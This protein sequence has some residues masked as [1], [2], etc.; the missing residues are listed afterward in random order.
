SCDPVTEE[1]SSEPNDIPSQA[2]ALEEG[3]YIGGVC[4]GSPDF[5]SITP[6]RPDGR[7]IF[8]IEF[9][10]KDGDL[11]FYLWDPETDRAV[12]DGQ[13]N[14]VGSDSSDDDEVF[15]GQGT[16]TIKIF[17]YNGSTAVYNIYLRY[18]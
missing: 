10:Q 15:Q 6:L 9:S 7:W 3:D 8:E 2:V 13:G 16:A 14:P 17:G 5:Y 4:D 18:L 12:V 1:E 11:D